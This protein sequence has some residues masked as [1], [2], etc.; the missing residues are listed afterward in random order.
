MNIFDS[1]VEATF[2]GWAMRRAAA[3]EQLAA[4]HQVIAPANREILASHRGGI[5]TRTSTQWSQPNTYRGGNSSDRLNQASR[6]ARAMQVYKTHP[7]GRSLLKTETD[8][9]ISCGFTLQAKTGSDAF[10]GEAEE[11]WPEFLENADI[12]GI[13]SGCD[14]VRQFY[15]S[16]RRDGDGGI[17]LVDRGG[18]SK[19]QYIPRQLIVSPDGKQGQKNIIDGIEVDDWTRPLAFHVKAEDEWGKRKFE[20]VPASN[21][22]Y[23]VPELDD[24]L[25][26][27][28]DS[29]YSQIFGLLDQLDGYTDAVIIAARMAAVFGLIFKEDTAAKQF[30]GLGSLTNSQGEQQK[31]ITL[32]NGMIKYMGK[33]GQAV[34]VQA[35]QPMNQTPDF[36]RAICRIIGAPF[37]MPLELV[38]KDLSQVNFSSARI[39]LIG[40]YRACRARQKTFR[41]RCL[42]RIYQWWLSREVKLGNFVT[43]APERFWNHKFMAEGWD[44]TDPVSEAQADQLQ[45]D[46]GIKTKSMAAAERGR[47]LEEM[48][49]ERKAEV[50][51]EKLAGLP[52]FASTMTRDVTDPEEAATAPATGDPTNDE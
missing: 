8:N 31:G 5:P 1:V 42:S 14:L 10:D 28:G 47:D 12:R 46:M 22:L 7:I 30:A 23:L 29:C 9:V 34:Q 52:Q 26:L 11:K 36:I 15:L 50:A 33:E 44:Y 6:A 20:R 19:L 40:Y 13:K 18:E 37:D 39:G 48:T 4:Y 49:V 16:P 38:C 45:I 3:R 43:A 21:F 27:R 25:G 32:E 41:T 35:Q 24:D 51:A 2:P 17:V